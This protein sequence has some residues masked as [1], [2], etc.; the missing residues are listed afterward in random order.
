MR[1]KAAVFSFLLALL[2]LGFQPL[3]GKEKLPTNPDKGDIVL[4]GVVLVP[5]DGTNT[6]VPGLAA[7]QGAL[8]W[9]P[10]AVLTR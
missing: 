4:A 9:S 10:I 1:P 6:G 7:L 2:A 5:G 8:G 3:L